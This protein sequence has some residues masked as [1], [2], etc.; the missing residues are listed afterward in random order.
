MVSVSTMTAAASGRSARPSIRRLLALAVLAVVDV[1]V[2]RS[3]GEFFGEGIWFLGV[4]IVILLIGINAALLLRR[5]M[6]WRWLGPGLSMLVLLT[7]API[8]YTGYVAVSNYDATH[9]LTQTQAIEAL[10]QESFLP[11]DA[12][13]YR[14]AAY[15]SADGGF[16]LWLVPSTGAPLLAEPGQSPEETIPGSDGVG[17]LDAGGFPTTLEGYER[18]DRV[19]TVASLTALARQTFGTTEDAIRITSLDAAAGYQ[20]RYAYDHD[21]GMLTDRQTGTTYEAV[22]GTFTSASG[23]TVS[24]SFQ[25]VVGLDNF[26]RLLGDSD[27]R[28]AVLDIFL[29]TIIFALSVVGVQFVIGLAIALAL[30][31]PVIPPRVAKA[32]RS[33]LLL[34][35][36]IP[37]YLTILVWGALLN[38]NIG[39]IPLTLEKFF[40]I[41]TGW[42]DDPTGAKIAVLLVAF[43]LGFPYFLLITSGAL[44]AIPGDLLEA[45]MVDGAGA[46]RRFKDV[47]L[48][49]L[50]R[51]LA[52]L[53]V[54]GLAFNFNNF[55]V[56]YLLKGGGPQMADAPPPAGETDLLISYTY[57]L[58][59][60]FGRNDYALAA[61]ITLFIFAILVP[62]V[63]SQFRHFHVWSEER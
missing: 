52:P 54:L 27:I 15:E 50:L 42:V 32:V 44:Q 41:D 28:S 22:E 23:E 53:I 57:K 8:V 16:A 2:L 37:A 20:Q 18:L 6:P 38:Q 29:W 10:E 58:S 13:V 17:Q 60:E 31:D 35:Y 25:A 39:V 55:L 12:P 19:E 63:V 24:P 62:I 7:L 45:A 5:L 1:L 36:V 21:T 40:G 30:N 4:A 49:L 34:P 61:V 26:Q 43:W 9:L 47:V 46:W 14:W 59:F 56:V 48:P 3:I 51:M 33:V 11:E